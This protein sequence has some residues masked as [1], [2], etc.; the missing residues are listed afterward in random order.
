M[1]NGDDE[2]WLGRALGSFF[3]S[4]TGIKLGPGV[5]GM[6]AVVN[7]TGLIVV[8]LIFVFLR[9]ETVLAAL[10]GVLV[11]LFLFYANERAFRFADRHPIPALMGGTELL[12]FFK[13]QTSARDKAIVVSSQAPTVGASSA[14]LDGEVSSDA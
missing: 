3:R 12:Q 14:I 8:G 13:D 10:G 2:N 6:M 9:G 11:L 7:I 4:A 1:A 5:L